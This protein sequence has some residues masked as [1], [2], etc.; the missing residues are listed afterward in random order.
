MDGG[1][2]EC[3]GCRDSDVYSYAVKQT[4]ADVAQ[5][6]RAGRLTSSDVPVLSVNLA[7]ILDAKSKDLD[8]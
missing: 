7:D 6:I 8:T 3:V 4:L 5:W 1:F 2:S